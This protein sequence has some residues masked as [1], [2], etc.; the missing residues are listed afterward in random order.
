MSRIK[1]ATA[2]QK[3]KIKNWFSSEIEGAKLKIKI[4]NHAVNGPGIRGKKLPAIPKR[5]KNPETEISKISI[6]K[7][8]FF[9]RVGQIL[10]LRNR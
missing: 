2:I 9:K 6:C 8:I 4:P 3:L 5:I 1:I 10:K 7:N